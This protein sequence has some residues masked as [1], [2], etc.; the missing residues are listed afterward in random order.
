M[1]IQLIGKDHDLLCL[2]VLGMK[3][4]ARQALN[5]LRVVVFRH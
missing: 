5:A 3:A 2:Q 1:D 4:K